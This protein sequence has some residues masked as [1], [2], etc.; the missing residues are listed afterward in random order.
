MLDNLCDLGLCV[1]FYSSEIFYLAMD[2][3]VVFRVEVQSIL[4]DILLFR[5]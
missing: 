2:L 3:L 4:K 5:V 1:L